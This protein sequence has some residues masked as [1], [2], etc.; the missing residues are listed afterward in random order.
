MFPTMEKRREAR[1][2]P[3]GSPVMYQ[4]WRHLLFL[5]WEIE[6]A[7]IQ[8]S[9]PAGLEVDTH[10]DKAYIGIVPF[11]MEGVRPRCCPAVP[12]ISNFLEIN[13]RTYVYHKETGLPGVWFYSL[14]ANQK[15]A[16][17][18]ARSFFR[19][20][21]HFAE[22]KA[23]IDDS[24]GKIQY[25][26]RRATS[27]DV[28]LRYTYIQ[29]GDSA[30]AEPGSLEFFLVE[31]YWL[32]SYNDKTNT[33]KCGQVHHHPYQISDV[34]VEEHDDRLFQL[35]DFPTP[36][37]GYTHQCYSSEAIVSIYPLVTIA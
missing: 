3:A 29:K 14:D 19:L 8:T 28:Q 4:T 31:R 23:R 32:F 9:L 12:G 33:L 34:K 17:K 21:Y 26:S 11:F 7:L 36:N 20:P 16:V 27:P 6:K 35:N 10:E 37:S 1:S 15:L 13:L 18:V 5:H 22:M 30:M 25:A 2:R 24:S